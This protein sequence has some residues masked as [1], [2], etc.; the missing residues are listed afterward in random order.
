MPPDWF[1]SG[2][3]LAEYATD[4]RCYITELLNDPASPEVSLAIARVRPGTTTQLHRLIGTAERFL[5]LSGKGMAEVDGISWPVGSGDQIVMQ[6]GAHQR[7]SNTE[8]SD[9]V[10]LCI[11]T[12]RFVAGAY[13]RL[14]D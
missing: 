7:I 6:A 5:I 4:E 1:V 11:C 8:Q 14:G 3:D 13:D 2:S 12:P 10:F 9:L